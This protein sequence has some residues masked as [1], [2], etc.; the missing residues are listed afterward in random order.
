M[1][2]DDE[3][4][5]TLDTDVEDAFNEVEE[6]NA[7]PEDSPV[8]DA[9]EIET[10][11]TEDVDP[12]ELDEPEVD[13]EEVDEPPLEAPQNWSQTDREN[14]AQLPREGQEFVLRRHKDMEADYTKKTQET[15]QIRKIGEQ[16]S[17]L[18]SPYRSQFQMQGMDDV[19]AVRQLVGIYDSLNRNPAGTLQWLAQSYGIDL[20]QPGQEIEYDPATQHIMQ[21]L[22]TVK[23]QLNDSLTAQQQQVAQSVSTEIEAFQNAKNESGNPKYPYFPEVRE[24]MG[25]L[26]MSGVASDLASAYNM[27]VNVNP[28]IQQRMQQ[29]TQKQAEKQAE[30]K[31]K[32]A[33]AKAKKAASG[34]KSGSTGKQPHDLSLDDEIR[35]MVEAQM[36][37]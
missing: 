28:E 7:E 30:A 26:V 12:E 10:E 5:E 6:I 15:A 19:Q 31:R 24:T 37:T 2:K 1:P 35:Q 21:E 36:G 27:A 29:E 16:F 23:S 17:E 11:E 3:M 14:F 22:N 8:E 33:A 13:T 9:D 25:K 32:A 4:I 18:L 34:V 20:S